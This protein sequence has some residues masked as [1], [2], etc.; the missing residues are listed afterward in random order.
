MS[1]EDPEESTLVSLCRPV[2]N[3]LRVQQ[4]DNLPCDHEKRWN[5]YEKMGNEINFP[6]PTGIDRSGL[7]LFKV[8]QNF[9]NL[10]E[11]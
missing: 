6:G 5:I 11:F 3:F 10:T 4:C 9:P 1:G 2:S 8:T 7:L